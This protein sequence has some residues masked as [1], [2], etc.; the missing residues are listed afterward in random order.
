MPAMMMRTDRRTVVG[1][2]AAVTGAALLGAPRAEAAIDLGALFRPR[3]ASASGEGATVDHAAWTE[4]LSTYVKR[5]ADGLNRVDYKA[6]KGTGRG[7]LDAYLVMLQGIDVATLLREEQFAF[8]ANL[9]NAETIAIVLDHYPVKSIRNISL[10]G[11][12]LSS[13]TGGPW[14]AK[15]VKV[16]GVDISLDDIEHGILRPLFA[17]PR[18]HYAVNCASIGCPN[19]GVRAFSGATLEADLEA[20]AAGY[21]NSPRGARLDGDSLIAS[22]IYDWF[23]DDFGG[24]AGVLEHL[25]KYAAPALKEKLAGLDGIDD[26]AY[27]WALNDIAR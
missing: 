25:R 1:G 5:G 22:S 23:G 24:E 11:T 18:V 21:V 10:G 17:E 4:L 26:Y 3:A 6:F 16:K 9:Y 2:L 8:W 12:L 13:L 19:L 14:K 7:A 20:A 15:V 27:D